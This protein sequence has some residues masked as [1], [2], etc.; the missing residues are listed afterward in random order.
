MSWQLNQVC[1]TADSDLDETGFYEHLEKFR[2]DAQLAE[3]FPCVYDRFEEARFFLQLLACL[4]PHQT[5]CEVANWC[6]GAH[7]SAYIGIDDA[8]KRDFGHLGRDYE[9]TGL[10]AEFRLAS[11]DPDP[12]LRDPLA[13]QRFYRDLRDLRIHYAEKLVQVG[14]RRQLSDIEKGSGAGLARWYLKQLGIHS[15]SKLRKTKLRLSEFELRK[16][17]KYLEPKP[18]ISFLSQNMVVIAGAINEAAKQAR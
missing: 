6:L 2:P 14:S 4:E 15:L 10:A 11:N 13:V 7:L 9:N 3:Q 12:W 8:A 17:S 18:L 16:L 5:N 1:T